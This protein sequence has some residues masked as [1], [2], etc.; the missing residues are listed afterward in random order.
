LP[1]A[2]LVQELMI[3]CFKRTFVFPLDRF[4]SLWVFW[5]A[6]LLVLAIV[7]FFEEYPL[8]TFVFRRNL[9]TQQARLIKWIFTVLAVLVTASIIILFSTLCSRP[10][11]QR[12]STRLA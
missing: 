10:P 3:P 9:K 6:M 1:Y 4:V 2:P 8:A 7:Y 11:H 5:F 12:V